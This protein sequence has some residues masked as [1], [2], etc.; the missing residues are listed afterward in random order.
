MRAQLGALSLWWLDRMVAAEQPAVERLTWFWHG[1]FAT[2]AKKV[3]VAQLMLAQNET[4]RRHALGSFTPLAQAMIVD[5]ALL[6]WLDGNDN[7]AKAPNENLSREF[8]E[9]FALG[10]GA[11]HRGRR[12]RGRPGADRLEDRPADRPGRRSGRG[13]TTTGPSR[14]SA[15]TA[16]F[17]ADSLVALLLDQPAAAEFVVRRLWFR[18]VSATPPDAAALERLVAAYGSGRDVR[19]LLIAMTREAAFRDE[20][21]SL[22][23][24]PVEWAVGLMRALGVRPSALEARA[25]EEAGRDAAWARPAAVPP[26]QRRRLAGR[27]RV[28]DHRRGPVPGGG[29]AA[30]RGRGGAAE[31][32]DRRQ[33]PQPTRG[34]PAAARRRPVLRPHRRG[35]R[36]GRRP[37]AAGRGGRRLFARVR[38]LRLR[39]SDHEPAD[40]AD[41][42]QPV[43]RRRFLAFTGVAGAGALAAGATQVNWAD[44]VAAAAR[45]PL[46]PAA[47]VLVVV[48]L[49]GG[50]DGL[51]TVVPAADPA[52]QSARAELAYA[53]DGGA[54][55]RRGARAEPGADRPARAVGR[56]TSWRSCAASAT[57]SRTAATSGRWPSGRPHHPR[58]PRPPAGWAAG[59]T[60]PRP[61]RCWRSGWTT[62]CR[63]CWPGRSWP[64]PRSRCA[65]CKLPQDPL[66]RAVAL[67]G[68]PDAADGPWQ[69]RAATSFADLQA[70]ARTF[71]PGRQDAPEPDETDDE[72][73]ENGGSAGGQSGLAAQLDLVATLIEMGVPTR[74]YSVS[75]GGFDTHS[76]ERGTQQALL[77][78]LDEALTG[79]TTRLAATE[80]GRQVVMMVYSEFGR[81]V[82]AN[83]SDGT[84]HGTAGPVFVLGRGVTRRVLRGRAQPDRPGRR[85]PQGAASTSVGLRHAARPRAGRRPRPDPRRL[86]RAGRPPVR[87]A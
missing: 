27:R 11:L 69:A 3:K 60:P 37:A 84:D 39:S 56:P 64:R 72:P 43:T 17:A 29:R 78:Q 66:G 7:T 63:R 34:H 45:T 22:V 46:D 55:P 65:G 9:L 71:G 28:A 41:H 35:H 49:Y 31:R 30:A 6:L 16:D 2:S 50:N 47:G 82:R 67:L 40:P 73:T 21:S 83:A 70:A 85:R 48:T 81:R 38:R 54:R 10:H 19:A 75:L 26:A 86:L 76:D 79:F 58:P 14:S 12:T 52:Y 51:N 4:F 62:R 36:R 42:G 87:L 5:P 77:T 57:R 61:T 44:L 80:R 33:R 23:K 53:P 18:L 1:H 13:S 20:A 24:Q 8:M 15:T 32:G 74:V 25:P 68:R 59:W